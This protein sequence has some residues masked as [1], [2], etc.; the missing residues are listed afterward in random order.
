MSFLFKNPDEKWIFAGALVVRFI[1]LAALLFFWGEK[2]LVSFADSDWYVSTAHNLV[3]F[4]SL[5]VDA[6]HPELLDGY[7]TPGY[8]FYLVIF[9]YL[10]L[11]LWVAAAVQII[12]TSFTSVIAMRM[13]SLLR[14]GKPIERITGIFTAF[15]P[16]QIFYSV[17][18][19][20]D[21]LG[22][23]TFLG[24]VYFL[25]KFWQD[26]TTE[27]L[28]Q[29]AIS[30]ERSRRATLNLIL[31]AILLGVY[32]YIRRIGVYIGFGLIPF[33]I[34][35]AVILQKSWR[36]FAVY[37]LL[38]CAVSFLILLPW[39]MRN[40]Y[41]FDRFGISTMSGL[42]SAAAAATYAATEKIDV[43]R[44]QSILMDRITPMLPE[45]RDLSSPRNDTVYLKEGWK[46]ISAHPKEYFKVYVLALNTFFTSANYHEIL[47]RLELLSRPTG[48]VK[49][50]TI[51]FSS[52]TLKDSLK[53]AL[54]FIKEPY[55]LMALLGRLI[56]G[57][58]FLA[59]LIGAFILWRQGGDAR[60][61]SLLYL[62]YLAYFAAFIAVM[63]EGTE[64]R[65]RLQL[66]PLIFLMAG[67][68]V[69]Y[70][71][72]VVKRY[73]LRVRPAQSS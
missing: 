50:F 19:L 5:I 43:G 17:L 22:A 39:F 47:A 68:T 63:I 67:V 28:E 14:L 54:D 60:F 16:V 3:N 61:L 55:G 6:A 20:S 73:F 32:N 8:P 59:S 33:F 1:L 4:H 56:Y 65:H 64:S 29:S 11:P 71:F 13:V 21:A 30:S 23:F 12:I 53:A 57:P 15:E 58:I 18:I 48:G 9:V 40:Y 69:Y 26:A 45:Q 46:I 25:V 35:A 37:A 62:F 38:C 52:S 70:S 72:C 44:A 66:N 34:F 42:Y 51:I 36:K 24:S 49:S 31:S 27:T 41:A 10:G 7:R 2:I